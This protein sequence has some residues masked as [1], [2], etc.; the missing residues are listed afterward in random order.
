LEVY[1]GTLL[2]TSHGQVTINLKDVINVTVTNC[3]SNDLTT[4]YGAD[5]A[6]T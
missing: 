2:A 6:T 4:K 1:S 3:G 5:A